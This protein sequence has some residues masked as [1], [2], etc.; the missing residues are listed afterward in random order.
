MT[1]NGMPWY[2]THGVTVQGATQVRIP[3]MGCEDV[4]IGRLV[5]VPHFLCDL[6][7][8]ILTLSSLR[9]SPSLLAC[10]LSQG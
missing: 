2:G 3:A 1:K 7:G 5:K 8:S 4:R 10:S 9:Q 6:L